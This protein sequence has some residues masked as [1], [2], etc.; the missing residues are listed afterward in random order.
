MN[1]EYAVIFAIK[2]YALH[3]GPNLRTTIF[4]KGCPL[5]C[6]WCHNPEGIDFSI[7]IITLASKCVGCREC[8]AACRNNALALTPTGVTRN[9][10]D[11]ALC[12]NCVEICPALAQEA[13][14]QKVSTAYLL[15]EIK[16]DLIFYDQSGGGVTF[17]GGEPLC[18][19]APLL[20]L[21]QECG[22]LELHRAVDT[23]GQV[24][25]QVILLAAEHTDLFLYDLK[26]MDS[27]AHKYYTS[28]GNEQIIKN[29]EELARLGK[30]VRV[31]IPLVAGVN[32][33]VENIENTARLIAAKKN[34]EGVDILPY[35]PSA[36]AKYRKLGLE[37]RG[38]D[39]EPPSQERVTEIA[40]M[41]QSIVPDVHVGG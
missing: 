14:G 35:H 13:T 3:D 10:T 32:D 24:A 11:C 16:K 34:V 38:T 37:Y 15:E 2:R 1:A 27:A 41:F 39:F 28:V 23:S 7:N 6:D 25:T 9:Q 20:T 19:P 5:A 36:T 29:F 21:L 30:A 22:K 8:I 40:D 17:S 12:L 26:H 33:S 4:F 31:R 18:Q